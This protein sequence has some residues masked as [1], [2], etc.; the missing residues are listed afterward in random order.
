[1][2]DCGG[3]Y[4]GGYATDITRT[5]LAGNDAKSDSLQKRV[6]TTVL[7]AFLNAYHL[8]I[9]EYTTGFDIDQKAR[10]IIEENKPEGFLF[11]HGTGHG[12]GISVHEYPPSISPGELS[13]KPLKEGMCFTIEPGI[14]NDDWGGVRLENTVFL[15]KINGILKLQSLSKVSFDE[16]L[17]DFDM[18]SR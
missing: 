7:K 2:L 16:K 12:V 15:S 13:K 17:I 6:Y 1:M 11:S 10:S 9:D 14:Y 4:E 5:F 18:F 8:D 3:Y